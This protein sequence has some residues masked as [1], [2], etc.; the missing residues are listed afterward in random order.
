MNPDDLDC[1]S[2]CMRYIFDVQRMQQIETHYDHILEKSFEGLFRFI[3]I[4][5]GFFSGYN[6]YAIRKPGR[7]DE[8]LREYFRSVD[9]KLV[10]NKI[11]P[12]TFTTCGLITRIILPR[13]LW[14]KIYSVD[15][16]SEEQLLANENTYQAQNRILCLGIHKNNKDVAFMPDAYA[17]VEPIKKINDLMEHRKTEINGGVFS[18]EKV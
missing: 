18:F 16:D 8:L 14:K 13:G 5:P 3:H 12:S 15:P 9:E 4:V 1:L 11:V 10:S 17:Q 6:M 7:K 2:N